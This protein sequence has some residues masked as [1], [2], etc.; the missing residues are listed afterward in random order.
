[1][2][3]RR[4]L[5]LGS[6]AGLAGCVTKPVVLDRSQMA[7]VKRIG[8]PGVGF[9]SSPTV[10]VIN[11]IGKQFGLVGLVSTGIVQSNRSDAVTELMRAQSFDPR[12][13]FTQS[14]VDQLQSRG[15]TAIAAAGSERRSDYLDSYAALTDVDAVLDMY[16]FR[17]G[18]AALDDRDRS[19]Y[20]PTVYLGARLVSTRDRSVLMQD[21]VYLN[22]IDAPLPQPGGG[23]PAPYAFETFS[24]VTDDPAR[25]VSALRES[26][27]FA[28]ASVVERV[29]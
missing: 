7:G 4:W 12:A 11:G 23:P 19:P 13:S 9:P 1:M 20:R 3:A 28:A 29:T 14:V 21:K 18:F 22:G 6:A 16:V 15:L 26:L 24:Q 5:L 25:A 2:I 27:R 10:D 17:Y 8:I